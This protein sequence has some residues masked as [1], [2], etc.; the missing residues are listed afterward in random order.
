MMRYSV[1]DYNRKNVVFSGL[2]IHAAGAAAENLA[3]YDLYMRGA[4]EITWPDIQ[5]SSDDLHVRFPSGWYSV[6]VKTGS[7][8]T[9]TGTIRTN[10]RNKKVTSHI[11][12]VVGIRSAR[13]R[14]EA[15]LKK[16]PK[17]LRHAAF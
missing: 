14:Y 3:A 16:L 13:I 6:Q 12:A 9:K 17:E 2:H 11:L 10:L 5:Q 8:N 15:N 1:R 4:Q 7:E